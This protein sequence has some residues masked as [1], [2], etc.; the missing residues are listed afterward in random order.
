MLWRSVRKTSL[1]T[2]LA[3]RHERRPEARPVSTAHRHIRVLHRL[4]EAHRPPGPLRPAWSHALHA[5]GRSLRH[6]GLP[7]RPLPARPGRDLTGTPRFIHQPSHRRR[8]PRPV[9]PTLTDH[10]SVRP[11][12]AHAAHCRAGSPSTEATATPGS[13]RSAA[14]IPV[15]FRPCAGPMLRGRPK[16]DL[17]TWS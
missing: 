12:P 17:S 10:P 13:P 8:P 16:L 4:P 3:P 14:E 9:A 7:E 5:E 6:P 1:G 11:D 2:Y 15:S